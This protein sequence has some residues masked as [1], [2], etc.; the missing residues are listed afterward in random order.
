MAFSN[1]TDMALSAGVAVTPVEAGVVT[2]TM[3]RPQQRNAMS[4][5]SVERMIDLFDR[6]GASVDCHCIVLAGVGRGF[7]AGSDLKALSRMDDRERSRFEADCGRLSRLIGQLPRPVVAAVHGFAIGGGLTLAA[8]CDIVVTDPKARWSLPEVAIGLFPAWGLH[9]V[10]RR[11]GETRSRRLSWGIDV[12]DGAR[13]VQM[14]LADELAEEP[15]QA[16]LALGR[17]LAKLPR[18]Q[19]GYVKEYFSLALSPEQGD[20]FANHLFMRA[21]GSPEASVTFGAGTAGEGGQAGSV[22][23]PAVRPRA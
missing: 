10:L 21:T 6:L 8:A 22:G 18:D 12:V 2:M 13:A 23:T 3:D 19:A 5:Q 20:Q 4:P 15:L 14:G 9:S 1:I 16:A 11:C 7:C 17:K